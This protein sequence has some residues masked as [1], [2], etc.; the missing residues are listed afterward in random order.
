MA[1]AHFCKNTSIDMEGREYQLSQEISKGLW[2]VT[3]VRTGRIHEFSIQE[4]QQRYADG[5]LVFMENPN[6]TAKSVA[7]FKEK[8]NNF[9]LVPIST[10]QLTIDVR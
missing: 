4:L 2:Q 6:K 9:S 7:S 5:K 1:I 8:P 10:F 3:E